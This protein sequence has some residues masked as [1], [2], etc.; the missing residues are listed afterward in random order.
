MFVHPDLDRAVPDEISQAFA[1]DQSTGQMRLQEYAQRG[2]AKQ[3][4]DSQLRHLPQYNPVTGAGAF[5][6]QGS[7][8]TLEPENARDQPGKTPSRPQGCGAGHTYEESYA[9]SEMRV[10]ESKAE[11]STWEALLDNEGQPLQEDHKIPSVVA[12]H[13]KPERVQWEPEYQ[14]DGANQEPHEAR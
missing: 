9:G 3:W 6:M 8:S 2:A 1:I 14:L 12:T 4:A 5:R 11:L 13:G 7:A 10:R